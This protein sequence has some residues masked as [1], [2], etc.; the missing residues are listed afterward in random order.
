M[1]GSSEA[2]PRLDYWPIPYSDETL[3]SVIAR[4]GQRTAHNAKD[5]VP[6]DL[7]RLPKFYRSSMDEWLTGFADNLR[8]GLGIDAADLLWH[9]SMI[10]YMCAFRTPSERDALLHWDSRQHVLR[11]RQVL[12]Y[13][14][15][16]SLFFGVGT[17]ETRW[18]PQCARAEQNLYGESY[19]HL[20]HQLPLAFT[21]SVHGCQ[22]RAC[23]TTSAEFR[24]LTAALH[25]KKTA[26]GDGDLPVIES[27]TCVSAISSWSYSL[28]AGELGPFDP[29]VLR[30]IYRD[31]ATRLFPESITG[32]GFVNVPD[33]YGF[34]R[35]L[36][37]ILGD[38]R[39]YPA[40][41]ETSPDPW[42]WRLFFAWLRCE[43][44]ADTNP[45]THLRFWLA[46]GIDPQLLPRASVH[47]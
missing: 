4:W 27:P 42:Q 40:V 39:K 22:L 34:I 13:A 36:Q 19:W 11:N 41:F 44:E 5:D 9:T 12:A 29:A 47:E 8:D 6:A 37:K 45:N 1:T 23:P 16:K 20:S 28:L 15:A 24:T 3:A 10:P 32:S 18:C 21:C 26:E 43:C 25:D 7:A 38:E 2:L 33:V 14:G 31:Y 46:A 17:H 35:A 30:D